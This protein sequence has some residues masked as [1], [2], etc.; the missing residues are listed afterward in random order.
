VISAWGMPPSFTGR[1]GVMCGAAIS[2]ARG[3]SG[4][5]NRLTGLTVWADYFQPVRDTLGMAP[6]ARST[7]RRLYVFV[8]QIPSR[9]SQH[10]VQKA[11]QVLPD[12][13]VDDHQQRQGQEN[14]RS[15][16]RQKLEAEDSGRNQ[17]QWEQHCRHNGTM[18]S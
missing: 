13:I 5:G 6:W 7:R 15:C 1:R 10:G 14:K 4:R 17:G 8:S 3:A 2:V 18:D 12:E 9:N 11:D 16:A